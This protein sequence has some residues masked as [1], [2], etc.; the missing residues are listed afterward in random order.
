MSQ[1]GTMIRSIEEI[2]I[3][4]RIHLSG[5]AINMIQA[6]RDFIE[7]K[8]RLGHGEFLPWLEKLGVSSSTAANYMRVARS[9][10]PGSLLES[11]PYSKALALLDAP[12]EKREELAAEI[13]D[14][15]AAEIRKLVAERNRAAEA[16]NAETARA[17]QAEKDAKRF[18]DEN[19][20]L[21][22]TIQTL[23]EKLKKAE[24]ETHR[25][26]ADL[27]QRTEAYER[28]KNRIDELHAALL[29]AENNRVEVEVEKIPDDYDRIRTE[30]AEA[31]R[32]E[33]ELIDAAAE[34]EERASAAEA[35]LEDVRSENARNSVNDYDTLHLAMKTFL[36]S[37]ELMALRPDG[38]IQDRERTLRDV[39]RLR[40]WC[41]TLTE[42]LDNIVQVKAVVV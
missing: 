15:S 20:K 33:Q 38:L 31:R 30:L 13:G 21:N 24:S 3:S 18:Y 17:D 11:M 35:E 39:E 36:L 32:R 28:Q 10:A 42:R 5:A 27:A 16:V 2:T 4:A 23:E 7:A 40:Q 26:Q 41:D 9:I 6:G 22:V 14:R 8:D 25:A 12:E 34:A 29:V 1:N 19:G 37:C